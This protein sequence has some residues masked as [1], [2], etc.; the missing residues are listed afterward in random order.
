[1]QELTLA[2]ITAVSMYRP[3][4]D[5]TV[6]EVTAKRDAFWD[7][8]QTVRYGSVR[9]TFENAIERLNDWLAEAA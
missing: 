8:Y 9:A 3:S 4:A 2:E 7:A 1:M 6:E 5:A